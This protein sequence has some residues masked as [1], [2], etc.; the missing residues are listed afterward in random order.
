MNTQ[1]IDISVV[2]PSNSGKQE[3]IK[4]VNAVCTQTV[5]PSQIIIV[6]SATE[7]SACPSEIVVLCADHGINL[8]YKYSIG[9]LPGE[10][11]NIGLELANSELIGFIDVQ[12]LPR[13]QWLESSISALARQDVGGVWGCTLFIAQSRFERVVRDSFYGLQPRRTLPG[14]VFR[15][16][17]FRKT[18]NFVEWVRAGEDTEWM[19][20][21]KVHKIP[22]FCTTS[23]SIDYVGLI[24]LDMKKLS[25]KWLRNYS[26]SQDLPHLLHQKLLMCMVL[27]PLLVLI[28]FNW[29]YLLADWRIDSIFYIGHITKVATILPVLIYV[30]VRGLVLPLKRGVKIMQ[31]FPTRIFAILA[32][33][34][35]A[36]LVKVLAFALPKQTHFTDETNIDPLKVREEKPP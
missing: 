1:V 19:M 6:D 24:G 10:A 11:R 13:P 12:T 16:E 18:G 5:K 31:L 4:I 21:L 9:T 32:V 27:Y 7:R 34:L 30:I 28:A 3:L 26:A 25:K 22:M 23:A 15:R 35:I 36:D 8:A 14:S 29:N 2:I 33:C 20:R 17:I